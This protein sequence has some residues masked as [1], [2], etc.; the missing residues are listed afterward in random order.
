MVLATLV[1]VNM[2][3]SPVLVSAASNFSGGEGTLENPYIITTSEQLKHMSDAY[4]DENGVN[5]Y[6]T[7][8]NDINMSGSGTNIESFSG[9]FNGNGYTISNLNGRLVTTN[10][11]TIRNVVLQNPSYAG[12]GLPPTPGNQMSNYDREIQLVDNGTTYYATSD[13]G[14]VLTYF[15][16]EKFGFAA[17]TNEESG[18]IDNVTVTGGTIKA[19]YTNNHTPH[20][21]FYEGMINSAPGRM[22]GVVGDNQKGV[23]S[24]CT[25]QNLTI[26]ADSTL[27]VFGGIVGYS[28]GGEVTGCVTDNVTITKSGGFGTW[29]DMDGKQSVYLWAV[30]ALIGYDYS[31]IYSVYS[32]N[33]NSY[34]KDGA[35][36]GKLPAVGLRRTPIFLDVN[37]S[38]DEDCGQNIDT[39]NT[40]HYS[41]NTKVPM[42]ITAWN[43]LVDN[44]TYPRLKKRDTTNYHKVIETAEAS[45]QV[46]VRYYDNTGKLLNTE[47]KTKND[48]FT[49]STY[50]KSQYGPNG[51]DTE[52]QL[53]VDQYTV[54]K[55][56]GTTL[57]ATKAG[58]SLTLDSS[59][60]I[61]WAMPLTP[62]VTYSTAKQQGTVF[63]LN[64]SL[65]T[66]SGTVT[67]IGQLYDEATLAELK[68]K[69]T[70]NYTK[71]SNAVTSITEGS[72]G[73]YTVT[74]DTSAMPYP[75]MLRNKTSS[76]H[77]WYIGP[78]TAEQVPLAN[79]LNSYT[80][81]AI[82]ANIPILQESD[83][84]Y[85][86]WYKGT[87]GTTYPSSTAAPSDLGNYTVSVKDITAKLDGATY[88]KCWQQTLGPITLGTMSIASSGLTVFID[89]STTPSTDSK[90]AVAYTSGGE[91]KSVTY[92]PG[93]SS[94]PTGSIPANATNVTLTYD[95]HL[96]KKFETFDPATAHRV[97]LV[98]LTLYNAVDGK[99][100][101][102]TALSDIASINSYDGI[103]QYWAEKGTTLGQ[104]LT[105]TPSFDGLTFSCW[106]N[107]EDPTVVY[108][109]STIINEKIQIAAK[110][111]DP[112]DQSGFSI[113]QMYYFFDDEYGFS[114]NKSPGIEHYLGYYGGTIRSV[115]GS[116]NTNVYNDTGLAPQTRRVFITPYGVISP[117]SDSLFWLLKEG[118]ATVQ[119]YLGNGHQVTKGVHRL[120]TNHAEK[121][122]GYTQGNGFWRVNPWND[123]TQLFVN[124]GKPLASVYPNAYEMGMYHLIM[125]LSTSKISVSDYQNNGI[126][127]A[128]SIQDAL[129]QDENTYEG[130]NAYRFIYELDKT[131]TASDYWQLNLHL[132]DGAKWNYSSTSTL[133]DTVIH[134]ISFK[135]TTTSIAAPRAYASAGNVSIDSNVLKS[136]CWTTNQDGTGD[137]YYPGDTIPRGVKD[138]YMQDSSS[139]F[140]KL[141][142]QQCAEL[143]LP[144]TYV[145]YWPIKTVGDLKLFNN[146][147]MDGRPVANAVLLNDLDLSSEANW[148]PIGYNNNPFQGGYTGTFDGRGHSISNLNCNQYRAGLFFKLCEATIK[149]LTIASGTITATTD[150]TTNYSPMAGAFAACT[151]YASGQNKLIR[152]VNK[153]SVNSDSDAGGLIGSGYHCTMEQC[154]NLGNI[155]ASKTEFTYGAYAGGLIGEANDCTIQ[156]CYN[157]GTVTNETYVGKFPSGYAGGLIGATE[158]C[159]LQRCYNLG[160]IAAIVYAGGLIAYGDVSTL[161]QCYNLGN[162]TVDT[163]VSKDAISGGLMGRNHNSTYTECYTTGG[164]LDDVK[165]ENVDALLTTGELAWNLNTAKGTTAH[166]AHWSQ[167]QTHPVY[168]NSTD[169]LPTYRVTFSGEGF[170]TAYAYTNAQATVIEMPDSVNGKLLT[171]DTD[172]MFNMST[173][174]TADLTV[175]VADAGANVTVAPSFVSSGDTYTLQGSAPKSA[176]FTMTAAPTANTTY[177]IYSAATG[178]KLVGTVNQ[179]DVTLTVTLYSAP[180]SASTTYYI[181]AQESGKAESTRTAVTCILKPEPEFTN[182][183]EA[184]TATYGDEPIVWDNALKTG[185]G[186]ITFQSDKD[187]VAEVATDGTLT[188]KGVGTATIT[189][190]VAEG[191]A[192]R[193]KTFTYTMTVSPKNV[194]ESR[195]PST[196]NVMEGKGTFTEPTFDT[197]TGALTYGWDSNTAKTYEEIVDYLKTLAKDAT[198]TIYYAY[199][200]NGNYTGTITGT[201]AVTIK[202]EVA[203]LQSIAITTPASKLTY[204]VGESLDITD[205]VVTG[206]YSDNSTKTEIITNGNISGFDSS[207]PAVNQVLTVTVGDKKATYIVTINAAPVITDATLS[208]ISVNYDLS[209]PADV[210]STITWNSATT[211]TDAVYGGTHLASPIDYTVNADQLTITNDYL[212][213]Q[214]FRIGDQANFNISFDKG[215]FATL[216]VE[217]VDQHI[218]S[219]NAKLADLTVGGSTVIGFDPDQLSYTVELPNGTQPGS[220]SV[221]VGATASDTKATVKITQASTLPG[222]AQVLVTAEN[223]DKKTYTI[224]FTLK[225]APPVKSSEKDVT[226]VT[227]PD[228]ATISGTS[229]T[230]TAANNVTSQLISLNVSAA[231]SWKLYRDALCQD[232]MVSQ[233]MTL[234]EGANTAYVKVTAEDG[235]TKVYTLIITRQGLTPGVVSVTGI[236]LN[237]TRLTLYSN[238]TPNTAILTALITPSDATDK[239]LTW[240]SSNTAVATV[241]ANGKVTALSNGTAV[242][243]SSTND[244]NYTASCTVTVTTYNN[245]SDDSDDSNDSDDSDD[246]NGSG[247][248]SSNDNSKDSKP[249]TSNITTEKQ[250]NRPTIA[251]MTV[252]GTISED[253]LTAT[254]TEQMAK[255][256]I[257]AAND[258]AK[259][260]GRQ[261][262]GIALDFNIIGKGNFSSLNATIDAA[263]IDRLN[264]AN[265]KFIK[266]ESTVFDI[267]FDTVAIAEI[268]EQSSGMVTVLAKAQTKLSDAAK[269]LIGNRP[270]FDITVGYQNNDKTQYVT[271]FDK[272]VVTLGIAYKASANE[273]TSDIYGVYVDKNGR[274]QL[275]ANSSYADGKVTFTRNSLSTYG[276]AYKAPAPVFTDTVAHWAKDNI[277]FVTSLDLISGTST[278]TF[279]PDTDITRADFLMALGRLSGADVSDYKAS[280]FT[281]VENT[282]VAMPYIEWAVKNKIVQ[283]IG[284]G[285]FGPDQQISRQDITVMMV[286]Y[287]KVTGYKLPVA[288]QAVTFADNA[289]ISAYAKDAVTAIQQ[290]TVISGK[291]NNL[292]DP[293]G[294]ATR[295]EASTILRRFIELVI[296]KTTANTTASMPA[297]L[298]P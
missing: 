97:D 74:L 146:I 253:A 216:T 257:K 292:F 232:E 11:G 93:S 189:V 291:D 195:A 251:K 185:D 219:T 59:I 29:T 17:G 70:L 160:A 193:A 138:L 174:V 158:N 33:T 50:T 241:D 23:V 43:A 243:T 238:T 101:Y 233:I 61:T 62:Y 130:K 7:L 191:T 98:T 6:Y 135:P 121:P 202:Q 172:K 260:S 112:N 277:D 75:S 14:K 66:D 82:S 129:Y 183:I 85:E 230:A 139:S 280:S 161:E 214:K 209:S 211:V 187:N 264:Q 36:T 80:G 221:A 173:Q 149:D 144:D 212:S 32:Q 104:V 197:I 105:K 28:T 54:K 285:K 207:A 287:A 293:Q 295:A 18:T 88:A 89:D 111:T 110:Y 44:N 45:N 205:M 192:N 56:T 298:L 1:V 125:S 145:D 126:E 218:P 246:S 190:T 184:V 107:G 84:S 47:R 263:A 167:S 64:L 5:R 281:D 258:A 237:P 240:Y 215:A 210:I 69:M 150:S 289:E 248:D 163:T 186:V 236:K 137:V 100:G 199:A 22:G 86:V 127:N 115:V 124:L 20:D 266:I 239:S 196:Q 67:P 16:K 151:D 63:D 229:I 178:G 71:D 165:T 123:R 231:A 169:Q 99:Q 113:G 235:S 265:V 276:V 143:G 134:Y 271:N 275:L 152:C 136:F 35:S 269:K 181:S 65:Y 51:T 95:G 73:D 247:K 116:Y 108:A 296:D 120:P 288:Q 188:I 117:S 155:I 38:D 148:V 254:I 176:T 234:S 90:F 60:D 68:S 4:S 57:S 37:T 279:A 109:D 102:A 175:T 106:V 294:N 244:D 268:D 92:A 142:E 154:Y 262:D 180:T 283:G 162:A 273:E 198:A 252:S 114:F 201:I 274:P 39:G 133:D 72:Y 81:S 200:A 297:T 182:A 171:Y 267:T 21:D 222:S 225:A 13:D 270:V 282:D 10:S 27:G 156:Q 261:V 228:N 226:D 91:N 3:L 34:A 52:Y 30:G 118:N 250:F 42:D 83:A 278:T 26:N 53:F 131:V 40:N 203:T 15:F 223:G 242:I 170:T 77:L 224:S 177:A 24:N 46:E 153:A 141:T 204:T 19:Y 245:S 249:S 259:N 217:V 79:T 128:A 166:N 179:S 286:N 194:Q 55:T 9:T 87:D 147:V 96:I 132:C 31:K 213:Q 94:I 78:L 206:T 8:Q 58:D 119:S 157:S 2:G 164:K 220:A 208:P 41:Y 256:A 76:A 103:V 159:H 168:A 12:L 284:D 48:A 255:D 49:L 122:N 272:G 140:S 25:V 227:A 290:T